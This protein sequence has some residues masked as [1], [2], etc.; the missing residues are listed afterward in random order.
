MRDP[1]HLAHIRTQSCC[2][3]M[4]LTPCYGP[5]E[6]H[7][8]TGAGLA[9]KADDHEVM[10]LCLQHHREFHGACG[11]FRDWTK[12]QRKEWQENMVQLYR[13]T[14]LNAAEAEGHD[15]VNEAEMF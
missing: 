4:L 3:G 2:A 10:P 15:L 13:P 6:A 9:L 1:R 8:R 5:V 7:H 14:E 11:A 12:A